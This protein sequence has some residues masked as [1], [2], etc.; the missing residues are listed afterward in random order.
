MGTMSVAERITA[1][2]FLALPES[3]HGGWPRSLVGGEVV[4]VF[5]RS[6]AETSRF[7]V[8]LELDREQRLE[9]PPLPGFAL[10]L[11]ELFPY[12]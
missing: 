11:R 4:L 9:P 1:R 5:R 8:A 6:R 12:E 10:D 3:G 7:D 2:E